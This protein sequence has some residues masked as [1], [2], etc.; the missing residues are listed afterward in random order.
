[1]LEIMLLSVTCGLQDALK[2]SPI[3]QGRKRSSLLASIREA[4]NFPLFPASFPNIMI[5]I[6]RSESKVV[7]FAYGESLELHCDGLII[8][9]LL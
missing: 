2:C 5:L 4:K 1:M 8:M 9:N 6:S 3:M 7:F